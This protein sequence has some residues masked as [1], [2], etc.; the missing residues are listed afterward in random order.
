MVYQSYRHTPLRLGLAKMHSRLVLPLL[1]EY[2]DSGERSPKAR[3]W[4]SIRS[5]ARYHLIIL[6][7]CAVGLLYF[8]FQH[9]FNP[10]TWKALIMAL[11]Y[12]WGLALAIYL[13]GHG[14]VA[15]PRRLFRNASH[16]GRLRRIQENA[17]RTHDRLD[18]ASQELQQLEMQVAHLRLRKGSVSRDLQEWIENLS[19]SVNVAAG[20]PSPEY[21]QLIP[22]VLT[23]RYLADLT[24]RLARARHK[25][26]RFVDDWQRL[27]HEA[28]KTQSILDSAASKKLE[29][30]SVRPKPSSDNHFAI[31][32]PYTRH[33]W[34]YWI[35][36]WLRCLV[37]VLFALA[38]LC[39]IWSEIIKSISP[40]L[41]VISLTVGYHLSGG[42]DRIGLRGQLIASGWLL[43]MCVA[44]LTSFNDAKV[45]GNRALVRRNTYGESACWYASQVAKL[46][47]P[48]AYNFVTFLPPEVQ[49]QTVFYRFLGRLI[50]LTPLGQGFDHFLPILI[51][52]PA[53]ATLFNLYSRIASLCGF[54]VLDPDGEGDEENP[55]GYG[56]GNWREGR[57]L[58]ERELNKNTM[59]PSSSHHQQQRQQS[60]VAPPHHRPYVRYQDRPRL[61]STGDGPN[62]NNDAEGG[63]EENIFSAF[64][65]R[66]RNTIDA[67]V[68]TPPR[69]MQNFNAAQRPK[70]LSNTN[71]NTR[72]TTTT[73]TTTNEAVAGGSMLERLFGR[74][75]RR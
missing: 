66:V 73:T 51:L 59:N 42:A 9:G 55:T 16:S 36:P 13:M 28:A 70:W 65:H 56:T 45:W 43:Y 5:N 48:L 14:L 60:R 61:G 33:L 64:T 10:T 3:I 49:V 74:R 7:C 4:Y 2:V 58:I 34:Y 68:G 8:S 12:C 29:F 37:G 71:T 40:K 52:L 72:T 24:R 18:T 41:S 69:W 11:A 46:T 30:E 6:S 35:I 15:M 62:D 39:I 54:G 57:D 20:R 75:D 27:L 22:S 44:A 23:E 63:E 17:V 25:K 19:G 38:S 1:G 32:T 26:A 31:L 50:N 21:D 47:V 53:C 67:T